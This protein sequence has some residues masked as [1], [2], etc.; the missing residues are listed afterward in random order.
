MNDYMNVWVQQGWQCPICGRVYSPT[1]TM[2]QYCFNEEKTNF[3][4][5]TFRVEWGHTDSKT[6]IT[7]PAADVAEVVRCK[8]C[9]FY[10]KDSDGYEMCDN[11]EG[12]EHISADGFC[13]W[14]KRREPND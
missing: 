14:A 9:R 5:G 11:T 7:V 8:D 1:T 6:E 12:Y 10:Y 4:T 3:S 2:C 13:A